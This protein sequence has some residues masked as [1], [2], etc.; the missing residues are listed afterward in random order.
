MPGAVPRA[1]VAPVYITDLSSSFLSQI[2]HKSLARLIT[3]FKVAH[4][5]GL[6]HLPVGSFSMLI[7]SSDG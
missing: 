3:H 5:P 7:L 6:R 1:T 4:T 2:N